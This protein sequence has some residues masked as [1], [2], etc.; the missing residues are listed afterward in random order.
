MTGKEKGFLLLTS[1]L[2]NP[3]RKVL[4]PA[5]LRSLANRVRTGAR[6][7]EDREL[8]PSDLTALGYREDMALRIVSLLEE[9]DLLE[10]YLDRGRK[11]DC[12]PLSRLSQGY[13]AVLRASLGAE[14]PGCLW[15]KGDLSVLYAPK[16]ALVGSRDIRNLNR[17]FT[18]EVGRQAAR[19]GYVLVSGN[20]RGADRTAQEACL[21][22][23]GRVISIVADQLVK[24]RSREGML[25]LS[26]DCFDAEFSAHRALSRNRLIHALGKCV[27]VAQCGYQTGGTWDGTVK[28][29]RFAWSRVCC[30]DDGS[31]AAKQLAQMGAE[32]VGIDALTDIASLAAGERTLFDFES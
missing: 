2:G 25:Y 16:V 20:A 8:S 15:A 32:L 3:E 27:F 10:H 14:A 11:G 22:A 5:Q 21:K 18:E 9:E 4:T 13:P 29:L 24:Q 30:F 6:S 26:E 12:V 23:G 7:D 31:A 28:N 19:Q 17:E 1:Q